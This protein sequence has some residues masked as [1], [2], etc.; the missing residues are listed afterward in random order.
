M[1]VLKFIVIF[2]GVVLVTG[3]GFLIWGLSSRGGAGVSAPTAVLQS[4]HVNGQD[5]GLVDVPLPMGAK[6]AQLIPL[7]GRIAVHVTGGGGGD[8]VLILDAHT[9]HVAGDF[10]LETAHP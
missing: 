9:G 10:H 5:F 4:P 2:M 8:H 7:D 3:F 6:I 1:K